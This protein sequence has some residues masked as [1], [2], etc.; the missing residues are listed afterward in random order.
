V[1]TFIRSAL[2]S[3]DSLHHESNNILL[4]KLSHYCKLVMSN[5]VLNE[6]LS[7]HTKFAM[8]DNVI[9]GVVLLHHVDNE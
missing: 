9:I 8:S 7:Y 3:K 5:N 1:S 2:P 6:E 4:E